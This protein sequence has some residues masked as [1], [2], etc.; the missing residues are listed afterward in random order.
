MTS[1]EI[2]KYFIDCK[3]DID[4]I[5]YISENVKCSETRSS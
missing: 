3:K 2:A 4:S 1:W 5:I